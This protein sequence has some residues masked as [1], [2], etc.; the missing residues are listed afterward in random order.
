MI[1]HL[2]SSLVRATSN[3]TK[4]PV[5]PTP[6]EQWTTIGTGFC[7]FVI[8]LTQSLARSNSL[9]G[10]ILSSGTPSSGHPNH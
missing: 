5:L 6:A 3:P 10:K 1:E 9:Y 7:V 4:V 8:G 2:P